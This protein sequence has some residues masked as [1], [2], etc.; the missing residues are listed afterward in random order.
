MGD[1]ELSTKE[2][3][4]CNDYNT[5]CLTFKS[6]PVSAICSPSLDAIKA[7]LEPDYTYYY[8]LADKN[9]K[10]YFN[11]TEKQHINTKNKLKREGLWWE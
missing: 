3:L 11:H 9:R 7:A 4:E 10:I 5:R 6:L 1:R 8:F 2:L